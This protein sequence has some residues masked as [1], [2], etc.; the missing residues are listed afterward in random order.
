MDALILSCGTGGGHDAVA[1]AMREELARRGSHVVV[2]NPYDLQGSRMADR[3]N[4]VYIS[5][6]QNAPKVFGIVYC[7][8][9][10]YRRLPFRSPVYYLN[11]GMVSAM[12]DYLEQNHFDIIILTHLFP[13][14]ILTQMKR[15]GMKIPKTVYIATDYI[16]IPFTEETDCDAYII[17]D[18]RLA[19]EF[20]SK[21]IPPE[22]IVPL[23]IPVR[24][25]FLSQMTRE[26]AREKLNFERD[27]KYLL[28]SGGNIGAGKMESVIKLLCER[29]GDGIRV[30]AVCG[31]NERLYQ[32]L[33]KIYGKKIILIRRTHRM[34][35]YLRACDLYLTKPGGI[36]ST[37]AA[38]I[39]TPLVHLPP[40]PG[41]ETGNVRFFSSLGMSRRIKLR[42]AE[43]PGII[44]F[45]E[46]K[47]ECGK[48]KNKQ[49]EIV[50]KEAASRI[51]DF[52]DEMISPQ[53]IFQN[54]IDKH[55]IS[56]YTT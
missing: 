55:P 24:R 48:M 38:V 54:C 36:S 41:C 42:A 27:K 30:V 56:E 5:L 12:E 43:I 1:D 29:G 45:M 26:T 3:I 20:Q 11:G 33:A 18:Q 35:V 21:G 15:R 39:G 9:E 23:G 7:M 46:D 44:S 22:K 51:C 31:S 32:R 47:S 4:K 10:A 40:I 37:E 16:C 6:V 49:H 14:E 52:V 25:A 28:V 34:D 2:M 13:A 19:G 53:N 8:G 17:P 50:H